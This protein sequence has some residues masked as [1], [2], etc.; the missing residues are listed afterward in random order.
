M[1]INNLTD[2]SVVYDEV[3]QGQIIDPNQWN[4][5]FKTIETVV[6]ANNAILNEVNDGLDSSNFSI[7]LKQSSFDSVSFSKSSWSGI[8]FPINCSFTLIDK[9]CFDNTTL[10]ILIADCISV[11]SSGKIDFNLPSTKTRS[12][13]LFSWVSIGYLY[14]KQVI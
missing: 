9:I 12:S 2:L 10:D 11:S 5:N 3:I 6:N 1:A 8:G 14:L 13:L 4:N 7:L